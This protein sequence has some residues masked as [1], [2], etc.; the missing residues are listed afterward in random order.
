MMP[1][2]IFC[3][4][5]GTII[6]HRDCGQWSGDPEPVPGAVEQMHRWHRQGHLIVL[7]TARSEDTR[8]NTEAELEEVGV[9]WDR[10]VMDL[11]VGPRV[12]INDAAPERPVAAVA[13]SLARD[14]GLGQVVIP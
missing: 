7:T 13:Y 14:E 1:A 4:I 5:D 10:L 11:T 6:A 3:D 9:P 2:T 8:Q 12:L